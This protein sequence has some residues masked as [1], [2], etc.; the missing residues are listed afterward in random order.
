MFKRGQY[1][2]LSILQHLPQPLEPRHRELLQLDQACMGRFRLL[3]LF[4]PPLGALLH[5]LSSRGEDSVCVDETGHV[6]EDMEKDGGWRSD[7][8]P[9][10]IKVRLVS[11]D[12]GGA[13][14]T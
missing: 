3:F 12:A 1:R 2:A 9:G 14:L 13:K 11:S 7:L 5:W 6:S 10:V 8:V 4:A